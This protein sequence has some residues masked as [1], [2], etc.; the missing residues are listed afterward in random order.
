MTIT[1][2]ATAMKMPATMPESTS[3]VFGMTLMVELFP[4]PGRGE[5]AGEKK[6]P[7]IW[8]LFEGVAA[9]FF[10]CAIWKSC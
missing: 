3:S 10:K 9:G 5:A 4:D 8:G 2:M 7:I 1:M 6:K